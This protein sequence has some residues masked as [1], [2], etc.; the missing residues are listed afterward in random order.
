[1]PS[2]KTPPPFDTPYLITLLQLAFSAL[3]PPSDD[4]TVAR[5]NDP[6]ISRA[7][8][9]EQRPRQTNT[10]DTTTTKTRAAVGVGC[11]RWLGRLLGMDGMASLLV[12]LH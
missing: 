12:L 9:S 7:G 1:M 3:V 8:C 6:R 5:P 2:P 10:A 11:M 4:L